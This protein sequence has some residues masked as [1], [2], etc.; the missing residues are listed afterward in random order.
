MSS[1]LI[2][3]GRKTLYAGAYLAKKALCYSS[4]L[5]SKLNMQQPPFD[6][7]PIAWTVFT[8]GKDYKD[9]AQFVSNV[10]KNRILGFFTAVYNQFRI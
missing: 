3:T 4:L 2:E 8:T 1:S 5:E 7:D 6:C 10:V 9:A